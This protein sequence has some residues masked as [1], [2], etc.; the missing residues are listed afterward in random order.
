MKWEDWIPEW[1]AYKREFSDFKSETKLSIKEVTKGQE[2]ILTNHI[3]HLQD[4]IRDNTSKIKALRKYLWV[5]I[6]VGI[7][8]VIETEKT[9]E[10]FDI[11]RGLIS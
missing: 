11:I 9:Q 4:G 10:L 5:I 6:M 1:I 7:L 8:I 3:P 2:K